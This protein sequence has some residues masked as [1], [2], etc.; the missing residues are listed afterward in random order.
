MKKNNIKGEDLLLMV[1]C[2]NVIEDILI[3]NESKVR[4]E[5]KDNLKKG[6]KHISK[7]TKMFNY[8]IYTE[9]IDL[10]KDSIIDAYNNIFS[11]HENEV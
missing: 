10:Y 11:N 3:N 6:L 5:V 1:V 7:L 8:G 2:A 9:Q 4:F